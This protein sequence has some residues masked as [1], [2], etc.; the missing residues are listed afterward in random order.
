[1]MT[2]SV[3]LKSN[4]AVFSISRR[5]RRQRL[6]QEGGGAAAARRGRDFTE[7]EREARGFGSL[8][9]GT[10]RVTW[11]CCLGFE[12]ERVGGTWVL[13]QEEEEATIILAMAAIPRT[14][15]AAA[16]LSL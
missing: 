8:N 10:E 3:R 2:G 12:A 6:G 9:L 11:G 1:M 13:Q 16:R 15:A 14:A 7:R 4:S 5:Q